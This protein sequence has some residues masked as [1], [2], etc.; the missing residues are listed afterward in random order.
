MMGNGNKYGSS[1]KIKMEYNDMLGIDLVIVL[2][3][4]NCSGQTLCNESIALQ[5]SLKSSENNRVKSSVVTTAFI[6]FCNWLTYSSRGVVKF[7]FK[8]FYSNKIKL[9]C[10]TVSTE[11]EQFEHSPKR[12]AGI[13]FIS[14]LKK[15]IKN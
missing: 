2:M 6:W 5:W 7:H 12:K 10:A 8:I 3:L 15:N 11:H 14:S 4:K 13:S 9:V 1:K